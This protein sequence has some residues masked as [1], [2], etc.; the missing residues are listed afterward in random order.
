MSVCSAQVF[1][2]ELEVRIVSYTI[3]IPA[4]YA[5]QRFPGKLLESLHDKPVLQHVYEQAIQTQANRVIIA[6]DDCRIEQ[7]AKN[8]GADVCMTAL[9]HDSGTLRIAEVVQVR[10]LLNDEIIVNLQGDEPYIAVENID[11]VATLL[12][13][14]PTCDTATLCEI[15]QS[16]EEYH[17]PN[18][19]KVVLDAAGRALYFSRAPIPFGRDASPVG[20]G[21]FRHIG[22]Y[23]YRA[24]FIK[25]YVNWT[26]S[27][28][29]TIECLEQ[30]RILWHGSHIRVGLAPEMSL[31]GIDTPEDLQRYINQ[32]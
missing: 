6:T 8:F 4:R 21:V 18:V 5:S 28:I 32:A 2:F 7:V 9:T 15:I 12:Q 11:A 1:I 13:Q 10:Q 29:E 24:G 27:P 23:A 19:V 20:N 17:N 16:E 30:L 14:D 3:V 25:K 22:L 26:V 31:P